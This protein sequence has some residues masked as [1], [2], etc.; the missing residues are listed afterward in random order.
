MSCLQQSAVSCRFRPTHPT[1]RKRALPCTLLFIPYPRV[2]QSSVISL[3]LVL[4]AN[5][6]QD[7]S[8]TPS[9][10]YCAV[11]DSA[12]GAAQPSFRHFLRHTRRSI[13]DHCRRTVC[14]Y[15]KKRGGGGRVLT[16]LGTTYQ[17]T[18]SVGL[19]TLLLGREE[20]PE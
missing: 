11:M 3:K 13:H 10:P 6:S 1:T 4:V 8:S 18:L 12:T 19:R 14:V 15:M 17:W 9:L 2:H 7:C 16:N 20:S 5:R